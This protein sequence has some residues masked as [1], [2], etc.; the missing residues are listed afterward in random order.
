M[1][2]LCGV[3]ICFFLLTFISSA[4]IIEV[5]DAG[6]TDKL[7][8]VIAAKN[9]PAAG[10][11]CDDCSGTLIASHHFENEDEEVGTPCGCNDNA[12]GSVTLGTAA[13][14]SS[15]STTGWPSDGSYSLAVGTAAS[16]IDITGWDKTEGTITF[17]LY[18]SSVEGNSL[19][20]LLYIGSVGSDGIWIELAGTD[21]NY[22]IIANWRGDNGSFSIHS[23]SNSTYANGSIL[24]ITFKWD[25]ATAH[26]GN[27]TELI[28][29]ESTYGDEGV[30]SAIAGSFTTVN[31]IKTAN[32]VLI[33]NFKI[34]STWQ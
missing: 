10:S 5:A 31:F 32:T 34:Y 22:K 25:G 15:T 14:I 1:K 26:S 4:R 24:S 6:I 7:K 20:T 9:A 30:P 21:D 8:A 23:S 11:S 12:S 18:T 33:D 29:D 19:E 2:K 13:S 16:T 3:L 27:Y 28:V 17:D